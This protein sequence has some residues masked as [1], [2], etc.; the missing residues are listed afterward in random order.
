[1]IGGILNLGIGRS[2]VRLAR[3]QTFRQVFP[4]LKHDLLRVT[5]FPM[6][7]VKS[8]QIHTFSRRPASCEL[9]KFRMA[10]QHRGAA[11]WKVGTNV[12]ALGKMLK[13]QR[14]GTLRKRLLIIFAI[15][16]V[17]TFVFNLMLYVLT[18]RYLGTIQQLPSGFGIWTKYKFRE[19]LV[20]EEVNKKERLAHAEYLRTLKNIAAENHMADYDEDA[21]DF[22]LLSYSKLDTWVNNGNL[23]YVSAYADLLFRYALTDENL[24]NIEKILQKAFE[25]SDHYE[26]LLGKSANIGSYMLKN[27]ALRTLAQIRQDKLEDSR[28]PKEKENEKFVIENYLLVALDL[29][30]RNEFPALAGQSND[31]SADMAIL[32]ETVI[33]NN[34]LTTSIL[35]LCAYY[36]SLKDKTHVNKSLS[37]L[38][39]VLRCAETEHKQLEKAQ[40]V[41]GHTQSAFSPTAKTRAEK[42]NQ[43]RLEEL[44]FETIPL[45]KSHVAEILWFKGLRKDAIELAKQSAYVASTK[46]RESF[47]AAKIA[48]SGFTNLST[49]YGAIGDEE[50][51]KLCMVKVKQIDVPLEQVILQGGDTLRNVVLYHYFGSFGKIL[52]P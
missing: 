46:S 47:N 39:S 34:G 9:L 43:K 27:N 5:A 28:S 31:L 3:P 42:Q 24:V 6:T 20:K 10:T 37:I 33:V 11:F 16:M 51:R 49:M 44:Q 17:A 48:K 21:K 38:L 7:T 22:E 18:L 52:F 13:N 41:A 32:P 26:S 30:I 50:G 45:L 4:S 1:M 40:A 25:I 19:G 14:G 12:K 36:T 23:E 29:L 8:Q 2:T 15:Y 35:D